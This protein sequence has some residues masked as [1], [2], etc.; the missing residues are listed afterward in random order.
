MFNPP[1]PLNIKAAAIEMVV[2]GNTLKYT[3]KALGISIQ[4]VS[5]WFSDYLG[6]RGSEGITITIDSKI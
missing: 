5:L 3:S 6:Y 1:Y 2:N 4:S